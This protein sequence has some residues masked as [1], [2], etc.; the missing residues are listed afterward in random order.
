M[1]NPFAATIVH[2]HKDYRA[3]AHHNPVVCGGEVQDSDE[4]REECIQEDELMNLLTKKPQPICY[5]G[6]DPSGRMHVAQQGQEMMSKI[7]PS[8]SIF[9]ADT[10]ADVK[11][12]MAYCP[13]KVIEGNPCLDYIIFIVSL[14]LISSRLNEDQTMG[15]NKVTKSPDDGQWNVEAFLLPVMAQQWSNPIFVIL[16]LLS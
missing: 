13:S 14:G 4:C 15:V 1:T 6:S 8:S 2:P 9:M 5:D 12:K 7:D 3:A 16:A 11:V 10:E